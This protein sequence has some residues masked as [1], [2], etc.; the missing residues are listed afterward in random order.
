MSLHA[1]GPRWRPTSS[2]P[3][4]SEP[5]RDPSHAVVLEVLEQGLV[6]GE[7]AGPDP[8]PQ[9]RFLVGERRLAEARRRAPICPRPRRSARSCPSGPLRWP[10]RRLPSSFR[11]RPCPPRSRPGRPSRSA[12]GPW[13]IE[14]Y[15]SPHRAL[16]MRR[17]VRG[18]SS[19]VVACVA[20]RR[21]STSVRGAAATK[22]VG[23]R[24]IDV[25]QVEGYL[26]A[27]NVSLMLDAIQQA[28]ASRAHAADP[29]GELAGRDRRRHRRRSSAPS[30]DRRCRSSCGSGRRAPTP[31]APPRSCSQAA[32]LA[33][34]SPG[35]GAGPGQPGAARRPGRAADRAGVATDLA[36]LAAPQRSRSRTAPAARRRAARLGRGGSDVGATNGVRPTIG[37]V[38]VHLDGKTV[39]TAAG[40]R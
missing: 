38:I 22:P 9:L 13:P 19:L 20:R 31:R 33:F 27:P 16:R 39:T 28:N 15:G 30:T 11:R 10:V 5:L 2:T 36:A 25:V 6:G 26:D 14:C 1:R 7:R 34:V 21:P 23:R 18:R 40:D 37:E 24:G 4:P 17:R 29:P 12:R 3:R 32:H 35:S 8:R